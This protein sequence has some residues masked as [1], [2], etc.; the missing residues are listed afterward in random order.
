MDVTGRNLALIAGST[1]FIYWAWRVMQQSQESDTTDTLDT[2]PADDEQTNIIDDTVNS[3]KNIF[4]PNDIA[5]IVEAGRGYLIVQRPDGTTQKLQGS[6]NWRNNNPGNLEFGAYARSMGAIGTDGR[7]AVF[8]TYAAGRA[9]KEA[10]IFEG[11]NYKNLT[12]SQT[13]SR[14]APPSENDTA[15]Y[16]RTVIG[17]VDGL[18][19][20][21]NKYTPSQ[22]DRILSA[23]EKV[24]GFKP[25]T[26]SNA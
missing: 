2:P 6:R 17:A 14:Y 13:I 1:V 22:R 24:E 25:G 9:A 7:F 4:T 18:D 5:A 12:L 20:P 23:M 8:P 16:Q 3:I 11:S 19:Q 15:W 26:V 21:M 10:L